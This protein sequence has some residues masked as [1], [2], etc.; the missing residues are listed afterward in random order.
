MSDFWQTLKNLSFML[1]F[2]PFRW[3]APNMDRSDLGFW[4]EV[5]PISF[6]IL[7]VENDRH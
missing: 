4:I 3:K 7:W 6:D 2:S 1:T 5:G